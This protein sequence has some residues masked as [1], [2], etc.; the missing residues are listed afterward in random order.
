MNMGEPV[1]SSIPTEPIPSAVIPQAAPVSVVVPPPA[2]QPKKGPGFLWLAVILAVLILGGGSYFFY[3]EQQK[4]SEKPSVTPPS[5]V[6]QESKP[7][8]GFGSPSPST[9][10]ASPALTASDS[11]ADIQKDLSGTTI[12]SGNSSEFDADLQSL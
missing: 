2:E 10:A 8:Q 5:L 7:N 4:L 9:P 12:E 6:T 11:V 1:L 3:S